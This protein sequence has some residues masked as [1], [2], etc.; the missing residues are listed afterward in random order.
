MGT[1]EHT[2]S[3]L[4]PPQ[5]VV[6]HLLPPEKHS[7][8]PRCTQPGLW[9][10]DACHPRRQPQQERR[11]RAQHSVRHAG[12]R[13]QLKCGCTAPCCG[14]QASIA[15]V[16]A[17]LLQS[18]MRPEAGRARHLCIAGHSHTNISVVAN[19]SRRPAASWARCSRCAASLFGFGWIPCRGDAS[20]WAP[21]GGG[22][23]SAA[24]SLHDPEPSGAVRRGCCFPLECRLP[25]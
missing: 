7:S 25:H 24:Q 4:S 22:G 23:S 16:D 6:R 9:C 14:V 11:A 8:S 10:G 18:A 13:L 21:R 17:P 20:V 2:P 1:E 3:R 15:N 19:I 5:H 12:K